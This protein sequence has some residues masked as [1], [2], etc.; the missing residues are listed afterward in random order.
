L[1]EL[2]FFSDG[3]E[4]GDVV[5]YLF[6]CWIDGY[7]SFDERFEL[8]EVGTFI[9]FDRLDRRWIRIIGLCKDELGE[10]YVHDLL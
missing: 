8:G 3:I 2:G 9:G 5:Y 10:T 1:K 7:D 4:L 6:M